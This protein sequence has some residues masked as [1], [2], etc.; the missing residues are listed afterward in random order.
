MHLVHVAGCAGWV[1]PTVGWDF[2][3]LPWGCIYYQILLVDTRARPR[4]HGHTFFSRRYLFFAGAHVTPAK[5]CGIY[6]TPANFFVVSSVITPTRGRRLA[7]L[8][9]Q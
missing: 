5:C 1:S 7:V 2:V 9:R 6:P 3:P 4:G 8:A